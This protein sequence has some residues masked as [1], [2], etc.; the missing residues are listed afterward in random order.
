[1]SPLENTIDY[2]DKM[3]IKLCD[4]AHGPRFHKFGRKI[5]YHID[6]ECLR[7]CFFFDLGN[8]ITILCL[9]I[10]CFSEKIL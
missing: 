7:S 5:L 2:R 10:S 8:L 9:F 4:H 1:M 3:S 6:I